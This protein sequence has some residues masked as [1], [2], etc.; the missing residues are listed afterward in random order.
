MPNKR[1]VR[2][3][4]YKRE[5]QALKIHFTKSTIV[6]F[7]QNFELKT[8]EILLKKPIFDSRIPFSKFC[9][10]VK[11]MDQVP[12]YFE[13]DTKTTITTKCTKNV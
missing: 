13:A 2:R 9:N 3:L 12:R 11:I 7:Q 10:I 4:D 8:A 6:D 1:I 5:E